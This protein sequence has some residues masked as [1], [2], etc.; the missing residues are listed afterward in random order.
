VNGLPEMPLEG[1]SVHNM[2]VTS[3]HGVICNY[4]S[5]LSIQ[6]LKLQ[7]PKSPLLKL[8]QCQCVVLDQISGSVEDENENE[9]TLSG[10]RT[11]EVVWRRTPNTEDR[12]K[13]AI[14]SEVVHVETIRL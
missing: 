3:E 4:A 6:N 8:H 9:L 1:L 7:T 2:T 12:R 10:N 5:K 14:A 11:K 13:F